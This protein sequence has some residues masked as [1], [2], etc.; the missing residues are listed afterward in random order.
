MLQFPL[1]RIDGQ[2]KKFRFLFFQ[3]GGI[4]V[5][6]LDYL[7]GWNPVMVLI[8]KM[9][10]LIWFLFLI[11][12]FQIGNKIRT[13]LGKGGIKVLLG[14]TDIHNA[15]LF[16]VSFSIVQKLRESYPIAVWAYQNRLLPIVPYSEVH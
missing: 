16:L 12:L 5:Y 2:G 3:L 15:I 10:L 11:L 4:A 13:A 1:T 6:L 8:K 7:S 9:F 14:N